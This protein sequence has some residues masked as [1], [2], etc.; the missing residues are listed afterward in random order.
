MALIKCPECGG[1]VSSNATQCIHCG[2][3]YTVC[4]ECGKVY[5]G[6]MQVCPSCG[7]NISPQTVKTVN[8]KTANSQ[9]VKDFNEVW[10][11]RSFKDKIV[12]RVT[13]IVGIILFLL[14]L[15]LVIAAY[16]II[17]MWD[18][19]IESILKTKDIV[20]KSHNIII[21]A[22]IIGVLVVVVA[23]F[24]EVY[25]HVMCGEWIRKNQIDV[26][27]YLKKLKNEVEME[28][29][30]TYWNYENL[31]SAAYL[32]AVPHDKSIRITKYIL[33]VV[34]AVLIA[35]TGGI[36]LTQ[37]VDEFLRHKMYN[38][39]FELQYA[40]LIAA[41]VFIAVYFAVNIGISRLFNKRKGNWQQSL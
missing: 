21:A 1:Q 5:M 19:S 34:L 25:M 8:G 33:M 22:C 14:V 28:E 15:A 13:K 17:D 35:V 2:C 31:S 26:V 3:K 29:L 6:E 20:D 9:T 37:N 30:P 39:A 10:Q 24:E 40:S 23:E 4:P 36:C 27:P 12:M 38:D 16:I 18:G 7:F 41:A 11:S 32:S